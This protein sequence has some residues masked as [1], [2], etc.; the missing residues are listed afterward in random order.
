MPIDLENSR[1]SIDNL[2]ICEIKTLKEDIRADL[3][4]IRTDMRE[5][6]KDVKDTSKTCA[7]RPTEC[8]KTF[9]NTITY[10]KVTGILVLLI[11]GSFGYTSGVL[12]YV[13]RALS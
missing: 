10:W 8:G 6:R 1:R 3:N 11:V 2:I 5:I 12:T 7:I 13:M 4:N 9:L